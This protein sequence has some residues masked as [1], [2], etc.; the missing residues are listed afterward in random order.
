M[1]MILRANVSLLVLPAESSQPLPLAN[2]THYNL[3]IQ[4]VSLVPTHPRIW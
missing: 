1:A 4:Q 2:L 3:S